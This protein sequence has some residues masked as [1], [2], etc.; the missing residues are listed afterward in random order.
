[1]KKAEKARERAK[2]KGKEGKRT[3]LHTQTFQPHKKTG[4]R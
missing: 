1:M 4:K 3:L 2:Q